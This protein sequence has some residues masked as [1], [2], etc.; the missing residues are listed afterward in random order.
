MAGE[1]TQADLDAINAAIATGAQT[2][3]FN[4]RSVTYHSLKDL[5]TLRAEIVRSLNATTTGRTFRLG[6]VSKTGWG[7]ET[8]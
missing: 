4:N 3:T 1:Y 5:L 6:V 8:E 2:I 7:S